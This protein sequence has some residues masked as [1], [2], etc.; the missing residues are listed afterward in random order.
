MANAGEDE[1]VVDRVLNH[2]AK[3]SA[4]SA[5]SRVY[6]QAQYLPERARALDRWA[7]MVVG[8]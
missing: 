4:K 6:N 5:V 7:V 8:E 3:G 1:G 2:V